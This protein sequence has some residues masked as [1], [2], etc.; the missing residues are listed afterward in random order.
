VTKPKVLAP[1][2]R[3]WTVLSFRGVPRGNR[4][5][6]RAVMSANNFYFLT[7]L[8]NLPWVITLM[9][10]DGG[11]YAWPGVTH[12]LMITVWFAAYL[13]NRR[14]YTPVASA[15]GLLATIS[16]FTY[17]AWQFSGAAG[18]QFA[19]LTVPSLTF[20]MFA[21]R[22]WY[23]RVALSSLAV[24]AAIWV[25]L[26][27]E[28]AEPKLDVSETWVEWAGAAMVVSAATLMIA[29]ASFNDLYFLRER[30]RNGDL[31][32]EAHVAAQTDALTH[33]LNRRGVEPHL[34][35]AAE[36]GEYALA[37]A[38]LDRF[39]RVNDSLGHGAG[40]T[41]LASAAQALELSVG[42]SGVVA[43][44]GGEEFLV[45]MPGLSLA[46]AE[47]L[48]EGVRTDLEKHFTDD[49]AS[50]TVSVGVAHGTKGASR[51]AVLVLADTKLYEAKASGRNIVVGGHLG[52]Q[53]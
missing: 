23:L 13:V 47:L 3:A 9:A 39:K 30:K 27:P 28:F 32:A 14:G 7:G 37:I 33:L 15:V 29:L 1:I 19:L 53:T 6:A 4:V 34:E 22:H 20:P 38:D 35:S 48:M 11:S 52:A 5:E 44:W 18:F 8:A 24:A 49:G 40:D 2:H 51:D 50:V 31:L 10:R 41:V 17:L 16:Q 12:L 36:S 21:P 43:R 26:S 42:N 45:V 25:Y 46:D